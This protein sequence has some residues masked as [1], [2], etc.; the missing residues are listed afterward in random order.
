MSARSGGWRVALRLAR[1]E[2]MRRRGQTV[3]MLVLICLPVVAVTAATV[4]W[5]TQDVAAVEGLDR[6]MGAAQAHVETSGLARIVQAPDPQDF[7][8]GVGDQQEYGVE[9]AIG[10]DD[11]DRVLDVLGG[12]RPAVPLATASLGFRTDQ[13]L[14]DVETLETDLASPLADGLLEPV[15]GAYPPGPG[16]VVVNQALADRGPGLGETLTV[17]RN[18]AK[19][20]VEIE[21]RIVGI[22]ERTTNSGHPAASA[23]PGAFGAD[24][25][26]DLAGWLVGGG[27]VSWDDVRAL[28]AVG[29]SVTSRQVV[30][31]PPPDSELPSEVLAM[32]E[33]VDEVTLTV[34]A[35]VVSMVLLEVVLL[36]GPAFAVRA[37]AQ[38]HALALVAAAGGTP[39]QARRTVLASGVVVGAV[40]GVAGVALGI[41]LGALAVPVAQRF[42]DSR[43]GPFEVPWLLLLV[44]AGFG[45]L[46]AVLAAVVPAHSAS[47]QDVVAVLAG[48]RGEGRTSVRSPLLGLV[49]LG[50]GIAGAVVGAGAAGQG[51]GSA[52]VLIAGAAVVSVLGMILVVPVAVG[53]VARLAA[54]LPLPLRFAARDAARHRTRTVPAVAAVAATVAGVVALGIAVASQEA[55]NED[56]YVPMLPAGYGSVSL[57]DVERAPVD[58]VLERSLPV[59]RLLTVDGV[60]TSTDAGELELEFHAGDEPLLLSYWSTLGTPYLV[61]SEVPSYVDVSESERARLDG[62]LAAGGT[63]VLDDENDDQVGPVPEVGRL[64]LEVRRYDP[65][66]GEPEVV[67][68]AEGPAA[69]GRV[70]GTSP[71][72][73]VL[74]PEVAERLDLDTYDAGIVIPGPIGPEAAQDIEE[75]LAA[76]GGSPYFYVERGYRTDPAVRIVQAVLALLGAVLML[77]GT[78]TAT[79]LALSDARPDLATMA[80]VGA[81]PRTRRRVAAAYALVVGGVGALLGAPVGLIPGIAISRPLTR[82]WETGATALEIPWPLIA[83]VV[84]GLPLLTAAVVGA[85]ARGRLPLTA[86][87][88]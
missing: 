5:R 31:D 15:R 81:R 78:L 48:R 62:V 61:G 44:V 38:A 43:F 49:L 3:L 65:E 17:V 24:P 51:G 53:L 71:A 10:R 28:N 18:T 25:D 56:R 41:G 88:D 72:V 9:G 63:V 30:A 85:C 22:A 74:S 27:P 58:A 45:F 42:D 32:E 39:R 77:G 55:A 82:D 19:G 52:A 21:L 79:F 29:V 37:K 83:L 35:L 7:S 57:G 60:R 46:S 33:G 64:D 69:V 4:V 54:R 6:R 75:S 68:T 12:E 73:A 84:L 16:E 2:A 59:D 13:G 80:A 50:A 8:T 20:E 47:R 34:L 11:L 67:G 87:F 23:L 36:A 86:R 70:S 14:G 40:G 66:G 26:L 76:L 1:R